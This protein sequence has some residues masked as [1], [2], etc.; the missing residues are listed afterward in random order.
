MSNAPRR[1]GRQRDPAKE[2]LWREILRRFA[3]S[4]QSIRAFC[5][6]HKLRESAFHAWRRTLRQRDAARQTRQSSSPPMFVPVAVPEDAAGDGQIIVELRGGHV[7]R[8]PRSMPPA[9]L[10]AVVHA[11]EGAA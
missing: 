10:A 1:C 4:G 8:L 5:A 7:L 3:A 9:Q 2:Q 11:I 6:A